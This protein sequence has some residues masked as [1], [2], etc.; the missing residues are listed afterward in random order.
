MPLRFIYQSSHGHW[1]TCTTLD[2]LESALRAGAKLQG[3]E[4][5]GDAPKQ[6]ERSESK[7]EPSEQQKRLNALFRRRD[8]TEWSQKERAAFRRAKV[9]NDD[10]GLVE[11]YYAPAR[12]RDKE[13]YRRRDLMTL[14]NNWSGEVDRARAALADEAPVAPKVEIAVDTWWPIAKQEYEERGIDGEPPRELER[15]PVVI[16]EIV[17]GRCRAA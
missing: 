12:W 9:N 8:A 10:L 4:V 2:A 15:L 5:L 11:R 13:D 14:L 3:A 7:W 17:L 1:R 16:R 6:Q